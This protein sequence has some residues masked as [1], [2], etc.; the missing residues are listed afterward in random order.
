MPYVNNDVY[1][2]LA[3]SD[4][5]QCQAVHQLEWLGL[6]RYSFIHLFIIIK[7][8]KLN[9][10]INGLIWISVS[11]AG[12]DRTSQMVH[13]VSTSWKRREPWDIVNNLLPRRGEHLR[14]WTSTGEARLGQNRRAS[15]R[16]VFFLLQWFLLQK[17]ETRLHPR[18]H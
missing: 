7:N 4:F 3:K 12:S 6:H 18:V 1:L 16:C 2:D 11:S 10:W 9:N 15:Y 5:N 8:N 13:R 14:A 17:H